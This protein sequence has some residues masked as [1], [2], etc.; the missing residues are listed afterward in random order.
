MAG[1]KSDFTL[2]KL[3]D[4]FTT[5]AQR[6]EEQLS[7]IRDIP[8]ELIDDFPDH[9][10]KVRDDEDMMQLVE[11]VKERGVITPA[12]VRQK[13]D[14][15]YELVSGH[16]RKRACELAGFETL[17][18][19]I[20]D[21]N[22]DEAT[23]LMVESNFQRSEILPSEKAFAYKMRLEAMKRQAGRPRKENV[24]PVGTN[25]RTDEQIAQETGDSRNQIHRY[26][27]LTN[28]V[29]ELLEFV[30]EGRIKMRPAVELSY[31]DEDC[32]RDVVDEID[33][34]DATPSH[35]Q[36]IRMRKLFN[37]GNLTTEAIHAVMSE[38]KPNQKEKIVLRG[39]RVRQLIPK[40]IPV[41][42]TEDFVCKALEHYN[43]FLRNRAERDSR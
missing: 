17:R 15:R 8:L 25:L 23:I 18:S 32:Q 39:D 13:E 2:T 34:N 10:F 28:L 7:K 36:T 3:D 11:S 43:K 31:L 9:P 33:L 12:T 30:D 4:L 5:Q 20:V 19:E 27:R 41:S 6:D 40:N 37:E 35:D 38:E 22:R 21:L 29:S 26:V 1:R 16:R 14:G 42:Q 24:S